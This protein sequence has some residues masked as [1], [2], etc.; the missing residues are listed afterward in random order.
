MEI[1]LI[2]NHYDQPPTLEHAPPALTLSSLRQTSPLL[3]SRRIG[4]FGADIGQQ[5][6]EA[7]EM[8]TPNNFPVY[9]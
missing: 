3:T 1:P 6:T 2:P 9:D 8:T 4:P 7:K 5:T